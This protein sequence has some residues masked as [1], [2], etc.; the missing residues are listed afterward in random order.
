M[1]TTIDSSYFEKIG[2]LYNYV[3]QTFLKHELSECLINQLN[4]YMALML[5]KGRVAVLGKKGDVNL[6]LFPFSEVK[7]EDRVIL[8]GAGNVGQQFYRQ[9]SKEKYC[10]IVKWVDRK[11]GHSIN[12]FVISNPKEITSGKYDKI[13]IA[14]A[15]NVHAEPVSRML[16]SWGIDRSKIIWKNY[17]IH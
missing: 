5:E 4:N 15:D 13:I 11:Y 14:I 8:Y 6:F 9:I 3:H 12:D 17:Y 2:L 7:K 10:H 1:S 16:Q